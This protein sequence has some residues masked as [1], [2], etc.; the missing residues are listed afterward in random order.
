MTDP[1]P[2]HII[3]Y[4]TLLGTQVFQS[5]I[6]G[7]V[8]FRALPR[9]QFASLQAAIFPIYFSLQSAL[10]VVVALTASKGGQTLGLSGLIAPEN[11][12]STFLPL[13]TVAVTGLV[14]QVVLRPLTINIMRERKHQETRDGKKSYDPAP[15]SKE[16]VALNKRFGRVHG[17][18]SL[19]NLV[20][21]IATI[22]YGAAMSKRLE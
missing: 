15:H 3:S 13:A 1:R 12:F 8:A 20:S 21:L 4:G 7:V 17:V 14:N 19:V 6:G 16:M 2:Y 18:S 11:R 10:P 9:P 5:F 22:Y